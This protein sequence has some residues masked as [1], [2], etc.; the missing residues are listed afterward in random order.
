MS[1]PL[2]VLQTDLHIFAKFLKVC[3]LTHA[4]PYLKE[5][6]VVGLVQSIICPTPSM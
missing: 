5:H 2:L 4:K 1:I 6:I 3:K